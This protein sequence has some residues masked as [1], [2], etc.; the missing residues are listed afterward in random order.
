MHT[1]CDSVERRWVMAREA[2][3]KR[4]KFFDHL[5]TVTAYLVFQSWAALMEALISGKP[6]PE[7]QK[8]G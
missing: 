7:L 2:R 5:K 3:H 4:M 6:P 1:L 8:H